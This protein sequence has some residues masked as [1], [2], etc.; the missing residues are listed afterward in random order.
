[1]MSLPNSF[2]E[3]N[4]ANLQH[5]TLLQSADD[6][7]Y[8]QRK[9]RLTAS[10]FGQVLKCTTGQAN[11]I[12]NVMGYSNKGRTQS[13]KWGADHEKVAREAFIEMEKTSP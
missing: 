5:S 3:V 9:G 6:K 7:W 12:S 2:K 1:M 8:A 4:C 10:Q 11:I 13:M